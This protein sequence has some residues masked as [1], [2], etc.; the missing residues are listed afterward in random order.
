[1]SRPKQLSKA[2]SLAIRDLVKIQEALIAGS[3]AAVRDAAIQLAALAA[4]RAAKE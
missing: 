4:D 1:M 2:E 3:W